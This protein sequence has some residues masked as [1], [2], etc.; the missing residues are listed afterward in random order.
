MA[1]SVC[2]HRPRLLLDSTHRVCARA[3]WQMPRV[4]ASLRADEPLKPAREKC[5][6]GAVTVVSQVESRSLMGPLRAYQSQHSK[7]TAFPCKLWAHG[8]SSFCTSH[9]VSLR[10]LHNCCERFLDTEHADRDVQMR[11]VHA[12]RY[13]LHGYDAALSDMPCFS[14]CSCV[15]RGLV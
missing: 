12:A 10:F 6:S 11:C 1:V 7:P 13:M 14:V 5:N 3:L 15:V 4:D 8:N 9:M 2:L